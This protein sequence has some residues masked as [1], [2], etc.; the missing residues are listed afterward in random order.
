MSEAWQCDKC[1]KTNRES[2]AH[3]VKYHSIMLSWA[4]MTPHR[5]ASIEPPH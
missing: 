4:F 2:W 5:D 3:Y 1:G